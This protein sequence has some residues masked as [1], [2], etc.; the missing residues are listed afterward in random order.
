MTTL[1][2]I[3]REVIENDLT[4]CMKEIRFNLEVEDWSKAALYMRK[5][6]DLC[7]ELA[8]QERR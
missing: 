6:A 7:D 3:A 2:E 8:R 1:A 5:A 4:L